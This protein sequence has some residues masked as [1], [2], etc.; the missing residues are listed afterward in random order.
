MTEKFSFTDKTNL[1][2]KTRIKILPVNALEKAV[3]MLCIYIIIKSSDNVYDISTWD[4]W[5]KCGYWFR[6]LFLRISLLSIKIL[7][8]D[9]C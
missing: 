2:S 4:V 5:R 7:D 3:F 8:G 1:S 9:S 6:P